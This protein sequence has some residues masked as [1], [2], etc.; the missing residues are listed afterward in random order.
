MRE[1]QVNDLT[2]GMKF[3][4]PVYIDGENLLVPAGVEIRSKDIERLIKWKIEIVT[5]TG[6]VIQ[7]NDDSLPMGKILDHSKDVELSNEYGEAVGVMEAVFSAIKARKKPDMAAVNIIVKEFVPM[8]L[9][10]PDEMVGIII[11][12]DKSSKGYALGAVN[13]MVLTV[14]LGRYYDLGVVD[15]RD[16]ATAALLHDI[17]MLMIPDS[18]LMKSGDLTL[19][20]KQEIHKH[21]VY[22]YKIMT[23]SLGIAESAGRIAL[24]HHERWDGKGYPSR[25]KGEQISLS[26]RILTM[27]DVFEAMVQDRP[28][29]HSMIG[30][31]AMKQILSES[32]RNFD[33]EVLKVFI[34]SMGIYPIGS[35]VILNNGCIGKVVKIH[36]S[37][38]LRPSV[39][40]L[41]DQEGRRL[42][43]DTVEERPVIDLLT[44]KDLFIA[45]AVNPRELERA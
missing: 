6:T 41:I 36:S 12:S 9:D 44:D 38:P 17:G 22:S 21:P 5:T 24:Q 27:V 19:A 10:N 7:D 29:R 39:R 20:E 40:V 4:Q 37:V 42:D 35:I 18:I 2:D 15:M 28:Y 32:G 34:K 30:Y 26:S 16:L 11:R 13:S 31:T 8:I 45:R 14:V 1:V 3:D 43:S 33:P 25:L 23:Q